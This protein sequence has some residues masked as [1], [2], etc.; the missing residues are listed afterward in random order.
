MLKQHSEEYKKYLFNKISQSE[1]EQELRIE[2]DTEFVIGLLKECM[3]E[4]NPEYVEIAL[5]I[6]FKHSLFTKAV[7]DDLMNLLKEDWHRKHED[8]VRVIQEVGDFKAADVLYETCLKK[9]EYLAYNNSEAL[10]RK[11]I[12]ALGKIG[13]IEV[14]EKLLLLSKCEDDYIRKTSLEQLQ[15]L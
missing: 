11:C 12:K 3:N 4:R 2:L 14:K 13:G 5:M 15:K 6:G 8:I 7:Q 1:L 9:Y 10:A